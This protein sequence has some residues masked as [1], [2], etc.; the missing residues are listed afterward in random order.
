MSD[1][2]ANQATGKS[3]CL[4]EAPPP[5]GYQMCDSL[6]PS[7][8]LTVYRGDH[9]GSVVVGLASECCV[10]FCRSKQALKQIRSN[11]MLKYELEDFVPIDGDSLSVDRIDRPVASLVIATDGNVI[12]N[13]L[14]QKDLNDCYVA[15]ICPD[16]FL[17]LARLGKTHQ[18][19][20]IGLVIWHLESGTD[21]VQL[22]AGIPSSWHWICAGRL[23]F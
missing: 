10:S 22:D 13:E 9:Q 5:A 12:E 17:A 1:Y 6:D 4:E 19:S 20:C 3:P 15:S 14:M 16:L 11:A 21:V 8:N 18:L 23:A 2:N 7:A